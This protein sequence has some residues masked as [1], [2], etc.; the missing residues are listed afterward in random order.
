MIQ[1]LQHDQIDKQR[2]DAQLLQC[3]NPRVYALSDYLDIVSPGWT[4]LVDEYYSLLFPLPAR[5]RFTIPYLIQP[6]FTQQLGLFAPHAPTPDEVERFVKAIPR[7]YLKVIFAFNSQNPTSEGKTFIRAQNIILPLEASHTELFNNYSQNHRRNLQKAQAAGLIF[8][9]EGISPGECIRL[10]AT[11]K[12]RTTGFDQRKQHTIRALMEY[13][14]LSGM[15]KV[16]AALL[17]NGEM[18]ASAFVLK[19][20]GRLTFLFSALHT[21]GKE[22][23]AMHFLIDSLIK[24]QAT[25]KLLFDFEGS[26]D[27]GLARFYLGFGGMTEDYFLYKKPIF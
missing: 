10:F 11:T 19:F 5:K 24:Q 26:V 12:G 14:L 9:P 2:W 27:P 20:A 7:K 25:S 15:G 4:A 3:I 22:H 1:F 8:Q 6:L 18:M 13:G 17:P 16:C 23:G 21:K